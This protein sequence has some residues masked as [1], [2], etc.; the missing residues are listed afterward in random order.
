M[1]CVLAAEGA[2]YA[3]LAAIGGAF[4]ILLGYAA[5]FLFRSGDFLASIRRMAMLEEKTVKL[6]ATFTNKTG[7][8]RVF[9]NLCLA[10]KAKGGYHVLAR[11]EALPF[12]KQDDSSLVHFEDG[13]GL[14]IK[15]GQTCSYI[16]DFQ[17]DAPREDVY[18]VLES[19]SKRYAAFLD[20]KRISTIEVSF[21]RV[22]RAIKD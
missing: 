14:L 13:Y 9:K 5:S 6:E 4:V 3:A 16:L 12:P 15:K 2:G 19:A 17:L 21:H 11:L 10:E 8:N 18:L 22:M 7:K 1:W 20:L